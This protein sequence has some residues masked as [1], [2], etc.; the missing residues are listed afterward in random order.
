MKTAAEYLEHILP[1][2]KEF[3]INQVISLLEN[4]A[5]QSKWI[6][7]KEQPTPDFDGEYLCLLEIKQECHN[8]WKVQRVVNCVFNRWVLT[9]LSEKITHWQP[10]P[11]AP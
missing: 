1:N 6:D 10:L 4:F 3:G 11:K 9:G 5:N 2:Q 7:V 8:V